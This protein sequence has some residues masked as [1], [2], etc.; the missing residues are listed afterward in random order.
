MSAPPV[1]AD[2]AELAGVSV[3][4]VSLVMNGKGNI[5]DATRA[6]VTQAA[7]SLGYTPSAHA[8]NL[9]GNQARVVGY[10]YDR[11]RS[12]FNPVLDIFSMRS[13]ESARVTGVTCCSSRMSPAQGLK[14]IA[15][16]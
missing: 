3:A 6:R 4:T 9:R 1:I 15:A 8:R 5:S 16:S 7:Q 14:P 13:C 10:A 2:V 12:R 11:H